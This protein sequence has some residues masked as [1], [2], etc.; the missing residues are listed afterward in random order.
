[1][2]RTQSRQQDV[3]HE[4]EMAAF[5][6]DLLDRQEEAAEWRRAMR[7]LLP[8]FVER[9]PFLLQVL[10][11]RARIEAQ[12]PGEPEPDDAGTIRSLVRVLDD[13]LL[14]LSAAQQGGQ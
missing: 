9:Q 8:W 10:I 5:A 2:M 11:K 12:G 3:C 13:L 1:M 7:L 14:K 4:V 6:M